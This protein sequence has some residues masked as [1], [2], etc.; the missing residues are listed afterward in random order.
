MRALALAG[1]LG[2]LLLSCTFSR[3][4]H[5]SCRA[6]SDCRSAFGVGFACTDAGFCEQQLHPRCTRTHPVDY[7]E[8]PDAYTSYLPIG[9]VVNR[10]LDAHEARANAVQIVAE[11]ASIG[12]QGPV[13]ALLD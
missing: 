8:N 7:L 12:W 1:A 9:V 3:V 4:D 5:Q 10:S 13:S 2:T 6:H 11:L